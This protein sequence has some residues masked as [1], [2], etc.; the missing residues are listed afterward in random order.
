MITDIG[1]V[2][3]EYEFGERKSKKNADGIGDGVPGGSTGGLEEAEV[4]G[5][6]LSGAGGEREEGGNQ[7]AVPA[8]KGVGC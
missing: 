5:E 4:V 2:P 7:E 3:R 8:E 1:L 6:L